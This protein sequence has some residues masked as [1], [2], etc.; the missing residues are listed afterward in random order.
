MAQQVTVVGQLLVQTGRVESK[1]MGAQQVVAGFRVVDDCHVVG[2]LRVV[3]TMA[4]VVESW[5]WSYRA[6]GIGEDTG[7]FVLPARVMIYIYFF[8]S[9]YLAPVRSNKCT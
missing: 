5:T 7:G 4:T 6:F 9:G 1:A 3:E 8:Y 2:S